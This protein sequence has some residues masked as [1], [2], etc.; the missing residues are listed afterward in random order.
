MLVMYILAALTDVQPATRTKALA[1]H[2]TY[3]QK[4]NINPKQMFTKKNK[5]QKSENEKN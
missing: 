4:N 2:T 3:Q 1:I 5:K